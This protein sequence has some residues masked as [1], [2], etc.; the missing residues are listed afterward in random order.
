VAF[1]DR[2]RRLIA[3]GLAGLAAPWHSFAQKSRVWRIGVLETIP[4]AANAANFEAFLKAMRDVGYA[5]AKNLSIDYRTTDGRAELFSS[6]ADELV[7]EKVDL[8]LTRGTPAALAAAKATRTIPV[9]MAAIGEPPGRGVVASLAHPGGNVTGLSAFVTELTGK[10]IEVLQAIRKMSRVA[11]LLNMGNPIFA[12]QWKETQ[13]AAE[14]LG[15]Q[16]QLLDVRK[17]EELEAAFATAVQQRADGLVVGIDAVTQANRDVIARLAAQ[18]RLAAVY[19]AKEFADAGGLLSYGVSYPDLYHRAAGFVDKIF[20]GARPGDLPV[21]QP[22]KYEL[23][24]NRKAA[25]ALG[26][27]IPASLLARADEV[28]Q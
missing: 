5:E 9:V 27:T 21:E 18:H 13:I 1:A 23:V 20:K 15:M 26:L 2:R 8:I 6:L 24:I 3:L 7:R 17:A 4:R 11:A 14:K 12:G 10:R 16:A 28:I 22:T 25:T 19:A